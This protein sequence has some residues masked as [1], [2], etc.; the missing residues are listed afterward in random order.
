MKASEA[1]ALAESFTPKVES[2]LAFVYGRIETA[3]KEGRLEIVHPFHG[4]TINP[5]ELQK[6]A[7]WKQLAAD[8]YEVTH[9]PNPDP[10]HPASAPYTRISW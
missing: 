2:L 5:T 6:K 9:N 8:G 10:G 3:A 4:C 1:R 7:V